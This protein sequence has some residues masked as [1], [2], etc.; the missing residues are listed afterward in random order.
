M[1][2]FL[3]ILLVLLLPAHVFAYDATFNFSQ[4]TPELV[5]GWKIKAGPTKGGPYPT[6]VDCGK[7]APLADGTYN[8]EMPG[9]AF[10]PLY[11]IAVNY[12]KAK[13]ESL[14]STEATL[15]I[16]VAPPNNLKV[17][18]TVRTVAKLTRYGN[19]TATTT[20]SR[21]EVP[22]DKVV[23]EGTSSYWNSRTREHITNTTIVSNG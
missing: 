20:V 7:P 15:S 8:C 22:V 2:K 21:K 17:V 13:V 10:N 19:P 9:V 6:V 3:W 12:D 18:I 14:P 11:G 5:A 16:T 23:K 1:K 4:T